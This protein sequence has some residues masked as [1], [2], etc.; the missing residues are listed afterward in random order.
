[1]FGYGLTETPLFRAAI[2]ESGSPPMF[3]ITNT[4]SYQASFD[5]IVNGTGCASAADKLDCL[6]GLSIEEFNA[7]AS[8]YKFEPVIDGSILPESVTAAFEKS[9]FVKVPM[10][11]GSESSFL[12]FPSFFPY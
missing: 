8:A 1:M 3:P 6:R 4:S 11:I 5:A 9:A 10:L 7:T 12:F 2:L